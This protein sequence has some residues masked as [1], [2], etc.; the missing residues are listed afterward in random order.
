MCC[1]LPKIS[2]ELIVGIFQG[3]L[4]HWL[5]KGPAFFLAAKSFPSVT[6]P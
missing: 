1:M 5:S 6:C 3:G 4:S 2:E